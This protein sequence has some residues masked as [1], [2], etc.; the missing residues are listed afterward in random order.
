MKTTYLLGALLPTFVIG[1]VACAVTTTP[2]GGEVPGTDASVAA[3]AQGSGLP[4]GD[5]GG[6]TLPAADAGGA[7]DDA[8]PDADAGGPGRD[9]GF[10]GLACNPMTGGGCAS[11]SVCVAST[12]RFPR[13]PEDPPTTL[14]V[15]CV[16][17]A[18][19]TQGPY[20]D[21][22]GSSHCAPGGVCSILS[23]CWSLCDFYAGGTQDAKEPTWRTPHPDCTF[24][25]GGETCVRSWGGL[26]RCDNVATIP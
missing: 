8:G 9:G 1:A 16:P 21:C 6:G 5:S 10:A 14:T 4:S 15:S 25:G 7:G 2:A 26:G 20:D 22:G 11:G 17:Q 23:V 19:A 24:P 13:A 3:D 18:Q 12:P